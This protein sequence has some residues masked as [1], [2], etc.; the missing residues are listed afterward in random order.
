[1]VRTIVVG[2]LLVLM[3]ALTACDGG[4]VGAPAGP[5]AAPPAGVTGAAP[6]LD[7]DYP[8]ALPVRNQLL[9]G[10][11]LL[12]ETPRAVTVEQ[13]QELLPLWQMFRALQQGGTASQV[14]IEAVLDQ[15]QA[16]MTPE[17]LAAIKEM[18]LTQ[19]EVRAM[20]QELGLSAGGQPP[21]GMGPGGGT[22]LSPEEKATLQAERTNSAAGQALTDKLIEL[23]EARAGEE[24]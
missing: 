20:S 14:E 5:T 1:M 16:A 21:A 6:A 10:T 13:A 24:G 23:L 9:V 15:I 17:Q 3:V 11:L 19:D 7:E 2:I 12:E 22:D 8:D 18:R 4:E